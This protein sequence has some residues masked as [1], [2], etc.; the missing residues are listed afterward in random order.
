MQAKKK[1]FRN[2]EPQEDHYIC[3]SSVGSQSEIAGM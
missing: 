1:R 2:A 3:P